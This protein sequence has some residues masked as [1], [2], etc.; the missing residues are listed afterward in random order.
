LPFTT[1]LSEDSRVIRFRSPNRRGR[2][3]GRSEAAAVSLTAAANILVNRLPM[4]AY[5]PANLGAAALLTWF[6]RR[7]GA[8]W[9][10]MGM[11]PG[12]LGTGVR[13]G[14]AAAI[15]IA[16][17][18]GL[19]VALPASRRL[20]VDH[21]MGEASPG[22]L[23]YHTL[24]RIPLGTAFAEEILFRGALLGI[25]ERR[26]SR[27]VADAASGVLFG[28][29]HVVPTLDRIRRGSASGL[30]SETRPNVAAVGG[31]VLVTMAAGYGLAWLRDR[32]GSI[33][34]PV[35]AHAVLNGVAL[36]GAWAVSRRRGQRS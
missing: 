23:L 12:R 30:V 7:E 18:V 31:V 10:D 14:A 34:A 1:S 27:R 3:P 21:E 15:P 32:S 17:V 36:L 4:R 28:M 29:W 22:E 13:W 8:S 35:V 25:F 2:L 9:S 19:G 5:L 16:G 6:A 20:F 24:V 33:A 26:H 11:D